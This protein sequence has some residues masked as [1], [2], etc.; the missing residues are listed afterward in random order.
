M[1][2]ELVD[3]LL[4]GTDEGGAY[5]RAAAVGHDLRGP[6]YVVVVRWQGRAADDRFIASVARAAQAVGL[7]ALLARR[8]ERAVLVVQ[9]KPR[10][11]GLYEAVAEELGSRQG[12]LGIGGLCEATADIP[13]SFD[14][15]DRALTVRQQSEPPYGTTL[16]EDLGL[17]RILGRGDDSKEVDIF[18]RE[19]LGPLLNY[20]EAHGT[21]LVLTLAQYFDHGGNYD[22]TAHALAVHRSTLR[23]RLQR[24]RE[25]GG[26]RL[27]DADSRFHLQVATRIWKVSGPAL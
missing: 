13:R 25:V 26:R 16:Y 10:T 5:A 21:D 6:Q 7:R 20:D 24:I 27:D 2:R 22:E 14:M 8:S 1:R 15:A 3:D 23:Y 18:V 19:W 17:Y 11:M 12:A 4:S 9:G